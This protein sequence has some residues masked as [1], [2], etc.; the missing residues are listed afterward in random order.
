VAILAL[1]LRVPAEQY[2][3][4]ISIMVER[5]EFPAFLVVAGVTTFA[6]HPHMDVFP[7]VAGVTGCQRLVFVEVAFMAALAR[8]AS[9]FVS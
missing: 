7:S 8:G 3:L 9:V 2:V 5:G 6:E 1:Y 4:G